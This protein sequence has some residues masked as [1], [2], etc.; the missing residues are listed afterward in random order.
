MYVAIKGRLCMDK[1]RGREG[2]A[3]DSCVTKLNSEVSRG[4]TVSEQ[5]QQVS[6]SVNS[7][8]NTRRKEPVR[9]TKQEDAYIKRG[10]EKFGLRWS[11]I[12]RYPGYKFQDSR[13]AKTLRMRAIALKLIK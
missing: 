10:I 3:M 11:E 6:E 9:F 2:E 8:R 13:E 7:V 12:L 4:A 5:M 1:L